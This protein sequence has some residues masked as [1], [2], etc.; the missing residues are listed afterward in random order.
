MTRA[1]LA[2]DRR[3]RVS[4]T[5]GWSVA[6][7]VFNRE[8]GMKRPVRQATRRIPMPRETPLAVIPHPS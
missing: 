7:A 5:A 6:R 3:N 2:S 1:E 4:R 8:S